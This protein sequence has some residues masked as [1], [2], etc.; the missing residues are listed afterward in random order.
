[1]I[2]LLLLANSLRNYFDYNQDMQPC[3]QNYSRI[4]TKWIPLKLVE[5]C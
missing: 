5:Y 2:D 4:Q 1:M 3:E